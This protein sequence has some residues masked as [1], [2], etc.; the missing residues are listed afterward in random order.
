MMMVV[1][2]ELVVQL[3]ELDIGLINNKAVSTAVGRF[4][5]ILSEASFVFNH[6]IAVPLTSLLKTTGSTE[7]IAKAGKGK[8]EVGGSRHQ[9]DRHW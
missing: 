6:H 9:G 3:I 5:G 8:V 4:I 2:P 1:Q 7:S